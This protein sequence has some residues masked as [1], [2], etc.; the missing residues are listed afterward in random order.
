M[1][2]INQVKINRSIQNLMTAC[3]GTLNQNNEIAPQT[4][5]VIEVYKVFKSLK[6]LNN[7][8][9][10]SDLLFQ[11]QTSNKYESKII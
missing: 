3:N 11:I 4:S 5:I 8:E 7:I 10:S 2:K 6:Y 9:I 1:R